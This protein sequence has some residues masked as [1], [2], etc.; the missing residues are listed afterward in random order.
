MRER[1]YFF[2]EWAFVSGRVGIKKI[3]V[4]FLAR[5]WGVFDINMRVTFS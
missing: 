4:D 3:R 1:T 5:K 2:G